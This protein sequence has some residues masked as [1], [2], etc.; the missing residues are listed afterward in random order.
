MFKVTSAILLLW[1][2]LSVLPGEGTIGNLGLRKPGVFKG[3]MNRSSCQSHI[4]A[5]ALIDAGFRNKQLLPFRF[6]SSKL[7]KQVT[8]EMSQLES[9]IRSIIERIKGGS[10]RDSTRREW[11]KA[12]KEITNGDFRLRGTHTT[13]DMFKYDLSPKRFSDFTDRH[14][15]MRGCSS[16]DLTKCIVNF[17]LFTYRPPMLITSITFAEHEGIYQFYPSHVVGILNTKPKKVTEAQPEILMVNTAVKGLGK[18]ICPIGKTW[19][20]DWDGKV[21][22]VKKYDLSSMTKNGRY[23][24]VN[25]IERVR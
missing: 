15:G 9:D 12:V 22:W 16:T 6:D 21:E 13:Y 10:K 19:W 7:D 4:L 2:P 8:A 1:Y 25:W 17:D 18:N 11:E 3:Q 23:Y 5:I 24:R 14:F 20:N